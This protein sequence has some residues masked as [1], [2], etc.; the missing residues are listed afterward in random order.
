[1]PTVSM[2]TVSMPTD[3]SYVVANT[4]FMNFYTHS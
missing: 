2:Q 1:M 3:L 4:A